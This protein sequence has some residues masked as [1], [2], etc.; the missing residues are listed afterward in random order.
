MD[1]FIVELLA[2]FVI[3][4][5]VGIVFR[6]FGLPSIIGHVLSG[7]IIGYSSLISSPSVE[8]LR[9]LATFGVTLLLFLVGLE[10]NWK[11]I[12]RQMKEVAWLFL[13][14]TVFLIFIYMVLGVVVIGLSLPPAVLFSIALTFSSTIVVVKVLSEKRSLAG[15]SGRLTLGILLLQD[16]LAI[17]V[18]IFLPS[19]GKGIG[20][21]DLGL[22]TAK[23][24]ILILVV[25]V[26]GAYLIS[27]LMKLVIRS[28]EDLVLFSLAWLVLVVYG[29]VVLLGVSAEVGGLLAG[30]SLSTS[31]GHFQINSKIKV[32]RDVFLTLFFVL[33]GFQ[34]GIGG[35]NWLLVLL[36][37]LMVMP[38]KFFITHFVSRLVGL[39]GRN[40]ILLGLNM[41]QL[42][43]FSLVVVSAGLANGLLDEP[44]VKAVT[45]AGLFSMVL[46]TI[47]IAK[48]E[49][50][51]IGI[52]KLS[53]ILFRFGGKNVQPCVEKRN[54]I[55]L[56]G[57]DRT[58]KSIL[59][60]LNKIEEEVVVVDF[61]P[62]VVT[63]LLKKGGAAIFADATDPDVLELT[64][65]SEAKL[66]ISTIKDFNDSL[67]LL[68]ELKL[69]KIDVP[70]IVDAESLPQARELYDAGAAYV[71][72]PHFVNGLHVG[73]I[74][75]KYKKNKEIF[76]KYR[77]KQD[78]V[79]RST[80][81]GEY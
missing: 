25:N 19:V 74:V 50:L 72:F 7:L 55:V 8:V 37:L 23:L 81:E 12:L 45:M 36:L 62:H 79:L 49:K 4:V 39:S 63:E 17:G 60:L 9:L 35:V 31:W 52:S 68:S 70:V 30:L 1:L 56:F 14:Q 6:Y 22:L 26:I 48:S 77:N 58:G 10:M 71:M 2:V 32:L 11:D 73:Q 42:S 78:S 65:I 16:M 67:S 24:L 29:S 3:A 33:L 40:S 15:Y 27:Q 38:V 75:K 57:G 47:L 34:V 80:Y 61:N 44:L 13:G 21:I 53:K 20:I 69:K 64:N 46:S 41:T 59:S 5:L 43:E 28:A 76:K 18:L 54:H 66:V 51:S